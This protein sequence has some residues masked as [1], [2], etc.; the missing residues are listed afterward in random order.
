MLIAW[1]Y[2]I[3]VRIQVHVVSPMGNIWIGPWAIS[4]QYMDPPLLV[5]SY[6]LNLEQEFLV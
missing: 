3:R 4:P 2:L 5:I 1:F 6:T